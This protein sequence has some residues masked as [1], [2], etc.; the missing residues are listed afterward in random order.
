[1]WVTCLGIDNDNAA[2]KDGVWQKGKIRWHRNIQ[3]VA[4]FF[5]FSWWWVSLDSQSC[6][7]EKQP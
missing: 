2:F 5:I 1:M 7:G 6:Q 4:S 3:R